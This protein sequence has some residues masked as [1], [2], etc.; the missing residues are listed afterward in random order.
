MDFRLTAEQRDIQTAAREFAAGEF[1]PDASLEYDKKQQFP[2]SIWKKA[3]ELGFLGVQFP[4]E[5]GG[6]RCGLVEHSLIIEAFCRQD[7][8]IGTALA[9]AGFGSEMMLRHGSEHQKSLILPLVAQGQGIVTAA[10][11]EEAPSVWPT[12]T[13]A[14]ATN[15]GYLINGTKCFVTLGAMAS[16]MIVACQSSSDT[17]HVQSNFMLE[18]ATEGIMI[19]SMGNKVGM[20]MIPVDRVTFTDVHVPEE[21]IIG[22]KGSGSEQLRDFF[23]EV[24]VETGAM[25][26]G[27]AQGAW[28]RALAYSKK[29]GQFGKA[30][31]GFGAIRNKL[32]DAYVDIE[33]ARLI[34]Y[35]AAWSFDKGRPAR[36]ETLMAKMVST[37][38]AYRAT[39]EAV[40][41]FGGYGYMTEAHIERFYRDAKALELFME[42]AHIQRSLLA[43]QL[44]GEAQ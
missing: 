38:A 20:R 7:S 44:L 16:Y 26:L 18:R 5:S 32:T 31:A 39:Y 37:R 10:V 23:S 2:V 19:S 12:G 28:D 1:D 22:K 6:Q 17:H 34:T 8:G 27:I 15:Q 36:R 30:I 4:E 21:A 43:D 24:R 13:S 42:P 33:M 41:V 29:R 14:R 9:L 11:L 3:G 40:Q 35:K 25:G